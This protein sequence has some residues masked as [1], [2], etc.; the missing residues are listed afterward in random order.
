MKFCFC[1]FLHIC[2]SKRHCGVHL[3]PDIWS[4]LFYIHCNHF[5]FQKFA[6]RQ[7]DN[8]TKSSE[9]YMENIAILCSSHPLTLFVNSINSNNNN[10]NIKNDSGPVKTI[11]VVVIL[12]SVFIILTITEL[13]KM[14]LSKSSCLLPG[15][16]VSRYKFGKVICSIFSLM[17][18]CFENVK[19]D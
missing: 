14:A 15:H 4:H 7:S 3:A 1:A 8:W 16:G 13:P 10:V 6:S 12:I 2:K 9:S 17:S 18:T 11:I 19:N 5:Y